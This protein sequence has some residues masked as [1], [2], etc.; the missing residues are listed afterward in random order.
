[1]HSQRSLPITLQAALCIAALGLVQGCAT[2]AD[3]S[4]RVQVVCAVDTTPTEAVMDLRQ[5]GVVQQK[6]GFKDDSGP[7]SRSYTGAALWPLLQ[8]CALQSAAGTDAHG[9]R[10]AAL[11]RYVL[12]SGAEGYNAV[13][14]VGELHPDFGNKGSILAYAESGAGGGEQAGPASLRITAPG[15][16]QGSRYVAG[17]TRLE[18]RSSGS[19][20][21]GSGAA[22]SQA[23]QVLGA[24]GNTLRLDEAALHALPAVTHEVGGRRY[25]GVDL[26][27]LLH[28]SAAL[29]ADGDSGANLQAMY[30]VA[31]GAD[32]YQALVSLAEMSPDL[33]GKRVLIAYRMDGQPLARGLARLVVVGDGKAGRSV[34]ALEA[35]EV[36]AAAPAVP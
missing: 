4:A 21:A 14:S 30:L 20:G 3:G 25:T 13:F 16:V 10:A 1:M 11:G 18:V 28:T 33:G 6:V 17:L 24:V 12:A 35:I 32:G 34:S 8:A 26:W 22:V 9:Q 27:S 5:Q 7:Q 19:V 31:T 29:Q 23:V 15:D 2:Q 36:F